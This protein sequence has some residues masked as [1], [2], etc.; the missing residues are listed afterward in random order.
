M[1]DLILQYGQVYKTLQFFFF[2]FIIHFSL[3]F[4]VLYL[5]LMDDIRFKTFNHLIDN[6]RSIEK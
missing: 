6:I 5:S 1:C 4:N 2:S 3:F